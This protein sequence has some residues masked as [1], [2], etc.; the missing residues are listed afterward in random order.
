MGE[1]LVHEDNQWVAVLFNSHLIVHLVRAHF[2]SDLNVW[3]WKTNLAINGFHA[4][5]ELGVVVLLA[6]E[7]HIWTK[8]FLRLVKVAHLWKWKWLT[9]INVTEF[10]V[11]KLSI[12]QR[13]HSRH[14]NGIVL[15]SI[16]P[17][18]NFEAAC[19]EQ[20]SRPPDLS[21]WPFHSFRWKVKIEIGA[22]TEWNW[23]LWMFFLY[24]IGIDP[25][26]D[27]AEVEECLSFWLSWDGQLHWV[28]V[29]FPLVLRNLRGRGIKG[30]I[31]KK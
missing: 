26:V 11:P 1:H 12:P 5:W 3:K 29:L 30:G 21:L 20:K 7:V 15:D 13:F 22:K 14:Q 2:F 31:N 6:E 8:I 24:F 19:L 25:P 28:R 4:P 18:Q 17:D 16:R 9:C 27:V 23:H 10:C